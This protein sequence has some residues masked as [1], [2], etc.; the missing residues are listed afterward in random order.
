MS[1][2]KI[3]LDGDSGFFVVNGEP[4]KFTEQDYRDMR[5]MVDQEID[6]QILEALRKMAD[7][8]S[9]NWTYGDCV[10]E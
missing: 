9:E 7:G 2:I 1:N 3:Q 8:T 4:V 5:T 6:K 10:G